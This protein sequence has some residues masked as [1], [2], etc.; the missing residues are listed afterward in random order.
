MRKPPKKSKDRRIAE[1][2]STASLSS[3]DFDEVIGLIDAARTRALTAVNTELIDL[4]WKIGEHISHKLE[5]SAWGEG[6]VQ[7]LA[8]YIA[9]RHLDLK[10][11]ARPSLLRM[12]QFYETYS[13]DEKL[14]PLVR[15]LP[16]PLGLA[17]EQAVLPSPVIEQHELPKPRKDRKR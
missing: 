7:Q 3:S 16:W 5:S 14:S 8:D 4:Y 17:Q 9:Q 13:G 2:S 1:R 6:V 11:F 10:G 12:R 15:Q